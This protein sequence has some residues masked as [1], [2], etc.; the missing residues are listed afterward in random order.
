MIS[1]L[2]SFAF[3]SDLIAVDGIL[4]AN[5]VETGI[6]KILDKIGFMPTNYGRALDNL[7]A[8]YPHVIDRLTTVI[9]LGDARSNYSNPRPD[10]MKWI[11]QRSRRIIWL[12]PEPES[13][14]GTGDSEMLRFKPY[15][16]LTRTCRTIKDLERVVDDVL[17]AT[18]PR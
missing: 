2:K 14:W 10:I 13:F 16:H 1:D 15:C 11:Y 9:I 3:S 5:P 7:K 6:S 8:Q 18:M 4:D 12:N 17:R